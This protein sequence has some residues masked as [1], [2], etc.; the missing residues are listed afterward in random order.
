MIVVRVSIACGC[1]RPPARGH[2]HRPSVT[3][4]QVP[5]DRL[6]RAL[7][8]GRPPVLALL[9]R[10]AAGK[11]AQF[12][13]RPGARCRPG[14]HGDRLL[15]HRPRDRVRPVRHHRDA[16][17][18]GTLLRFV[19]ELRQPVDPE[20]KPVIAAADFDQA[21][22]VDRL[23]RRQP[24][25]YLV[26]EAVPRAG[27][28]AERSGQPVQ[29]DAARPGE[30]G[31]HFVGVGRDEYR[32]D[33]DRPQGLS[34]RRNVRPAVAGDDREDRA[35]AVRRRA[36]HLDH[37]PVALGHARREELVAGQHEPPGVRPARGHLPEDGELIAEH[38]G[39]VPDRLPH[40][41]LDRGPALVD[42]HAAL[43]RQQAEQVRPAGRR[44]S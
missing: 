21:H 17:P 18:P 1:G 20:L 30:H 22:Q 2:D 35:V 7:E 23:R 34:A 36:A 8:L 42:G 41:V 6:K 37:G 9:L 12:L 33:V 29:Q 19:D 28:L 5:G 43:A 40:L 26:L 15:V 38:Q 4:G 39:A 32:L 44:R 24:V 27:E 11:R 3:L 10:R 31:G 14:A 16:Q 13:L 25:G